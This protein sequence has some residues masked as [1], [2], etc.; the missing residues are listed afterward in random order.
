MGCQKT[1]VGKIV[2][3]EADYI[4]MVKDNQ[5]EQ[6][7][8]VFTINPKTEADIDLDFGYGR[9]EKRTCQA[10]DNLTFLDDQ[11]D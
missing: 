3:K 6:V 7:E 2:E 9:I 4:L 1:I 11:Q 5:P 10:I 8:K